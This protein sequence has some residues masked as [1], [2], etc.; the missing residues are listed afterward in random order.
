MGEDQNDLDDVEDGPENA[1][2]KTFGWYVVLNRISQNDITKHDAILKKKL[3]EVLNQ[4]SYLI[5]LDR[6]EARIAKASLAKG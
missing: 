2:Q 1:F 4:M 6:E 5:A 3:M